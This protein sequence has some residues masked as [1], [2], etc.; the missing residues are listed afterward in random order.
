MAIEVM[1]PTYN[2]AATVEATLRSVFAQSEPIESVTVVDDASSDGTEA[3]VR[4]FKSV[5]FLRNEKNLGAIENWA[6]CMRLATEDHV[7]LLHADDI[8]MPEWHKHCRALIRN[9]P[10][11]VETF[12][13]LGYADATV[14]GNITHVFSV[15]PR[16][17]YFE[18]GTWLVKLWR[19]RLVGIMTSGATVYARRPFLELGGFPAKE[20]PLMSDVPL[21]YRMA[22]NYWIA[23]DPEPLAMMT[24]IPNSL[25]KV[26]RPTLYAGNMKLIKEISDDLAK[27]AGLS[28]EVIIQQAMFPYFVIDLCRPYWRRLY[29]LPDH[30][31]VEPRAVCRN[32]GFLRLARIALIY[33]GRVLQV[34]FRT[35]KYRR[36]LSPVAKYY[37]GLL[38]TQR[39]QPHQGVSSGTQDPRQ[40]DNTAREAI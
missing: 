34:R 15:T 39:K 4:A 19:A 33:A 8:I 18:P 28:R 38:L 35:W 25:S 23:Y 6:Q 3:V 32:A 11:P 30:L 37:A 12:I 22:Q 36:H 2:S 9:A 24:Q 20:Y 1:I 13:V 27:V 29:N 21:H 17:G 40:G 5:K 14:S 10:K 31:F 16:Q 7:V 26:N